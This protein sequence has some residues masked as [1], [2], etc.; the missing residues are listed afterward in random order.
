[1]S[2]KKLSDEILR[3]PEPEQLIGVC[4]T[5]LWRWSREGRFPK[6][7]KLASRASGYL[8]SEVEQWLKDRATERETIGVGASSSVA[9]KG[10]R[11]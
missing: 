9:D 4:T 6:R 10:A 1:M 5:T 11:R 8:R 3:S 7:I 2:D